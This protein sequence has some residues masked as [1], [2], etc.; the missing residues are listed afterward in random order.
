MKKILLLCLM[1]N[2]LSLLGV[3]VLR[4]GDKA[5]YDGLLFSEQEEQKL[6][7]REEQNAARIEKLQQLGKIDS[8]IIKKQEKVI[9]KIENDNKS[10]VLWFILGMVVTGASIYVGSKASK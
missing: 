2:S 7:L 5:P 8:E 9:T 6:R 3:E 10:G 1:F 4:K